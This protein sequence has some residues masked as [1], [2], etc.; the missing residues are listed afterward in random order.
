MSK[1]NSG[2]VIGDGYQLI[3]L[4]GSGGFGEVWRAEHE[5]YGLIALKIITNEKY[6]DKELKGIFQFQKCKHPGLIE[7]LDVGHTDERLLYYT[8]PLADHADSENEYKADSLAL[9]IE[10]K[11]K[12]SPD[13]VYKIA[14]N[15]SK[16]LGCLH[17]EGLIHRDVKPD[18]IVYINGE[19]VLTDFGLVT[20][21]S[22]ETSR[23]GTPGFWPS[24]V[25]NKSYVP[26]EASDFYA[27]GATLLCA[28][29]GTNDPDLALKRI[30]S[31]TY[32]DPGG[33][34][35][36]LCC[37]LE[38]QSKVYSESEEFIDSEEK[39]LSCLQGR[40]EQKVSV[41]KSEVSVNNTDYPDEKPANNYNSL[42]NIAIGL[43][44]F[45]CIYFS[46][47]IKMQ[48]R[49]GFDGL[50]I[51][52]IFYMYFVSACMFLCPPFV[53]LYCRKILNS[54]PEVSNLTKSEMLKYAVLLGIFGGHRFHAGMKITGIMMLLSFGG[55][56]IWWLTD[57]LLLSFD[58]FSD[59]KKCLIMRKQ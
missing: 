47:A 32:P 11:K 17:K 21:V 42:R 34:L 30:V 27:L 1:F 51:A 33:D 13:D 46:S 50:N 48:I 26:C 45:A 25:L 2:D 40:K 8:M 59:N 7:I 6:D 19:P 43:F 49:E 20:V 24:Y 31:M 41:D 37:T 28:L 54:Q 29:A 15:I 18:N 5:K 22:Y 10:K 36:R 4:C 55:L 53:L 9:R 58:C 23:A 16:A 35:I 39:F 38:D 52:Q 12:I 57:V 3:S 14:E 44:I 56:G